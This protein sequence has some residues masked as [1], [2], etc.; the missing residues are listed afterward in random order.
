MSLITRIW[1]P[2]TVN[3]TSERKCG[4]IRFRA[5]QIHVTNSRK[6]LKASRLVYTFPAS[7]SSRRRKYT[8]RTARASRTGNGIA[9]VYTRSRKKKG[10]VFVGYKRNFMRNTIFTKCE[11]IGNGMKKPLH[12]RSKTK[13][14]CERAEARHG[15]FPVFRFA[16]PTCV[17]QPTPWTKITDQQ[18]SNYFE[19]SGMMR[20][21]V[22]S[23]GVLAVTCRN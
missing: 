6:M 15:E 7:A 18:S 9:S 14:K 1:E 20:E 10:T 16:V 22:Q 11:F 17:I 23:R 13:K 19:V 8:A 4:G 5:M 21:R 12:N 2:Y 3:E